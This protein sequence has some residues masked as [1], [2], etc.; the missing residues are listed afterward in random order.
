MKV[1]LP[2]PL[3]KVTLEMGLNVIPQM[4]DMQFMQ[5]Q[6][7]SSI[8]NQVMDMVERGLIGK[9][10]EMESAAGDTMEIVVK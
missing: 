9:I 7:W 8:L 2:I 5:G 1:T 6:D 10:F 4:E 3:V